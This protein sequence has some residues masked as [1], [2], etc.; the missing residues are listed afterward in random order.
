MYDHLLFD[1]DGT[2]YD[3]MAAENYALKKLFAETGLQATEEMIETYHEIN[4]SLWLDLERGGTTVE[5]LKSERFSRFFRTYGV[6]FDAADASDRYVYHLGTSY[7][8]FDDTIR[9][10]GQLK[11]MGYRMSII[12]NG[13]TSVQKGRVQ[14]TGTASF[15]SYVAIAEE[16]GFVK[17]DPMFFTETFR[18]LEKLGI[19]PENPLVIGDSLSSDIEG[20]RRAGLDSVWINRYGM[21]IPETP[22]YTYRID[23]LEELIG[24]L[25][26]S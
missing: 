24:I 23:T 9:V 11:G 2:L 20:A 14:A 7:H 3:F 10:L 12:T 18:E 22:S 19:H 8:V 17:P 21:E 5:E 25:T 6:H 1:A 4:H 13:I 16:L 26:D 15:F